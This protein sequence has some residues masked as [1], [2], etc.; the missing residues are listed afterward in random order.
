[1]LFRL[2]VLSID[3]INNLQNVQN[4][5]YLKTGWFYCQHLLI[6][7]RLGEPTSPLPARKGGWKGLEQGLKFTFPPW[8]KFFNT[9]GLDFTLNPIRTI[10]R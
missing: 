3:K 6:N 2:L 1:M 4:H 9:K 8:H 7:F 10:V 5:K